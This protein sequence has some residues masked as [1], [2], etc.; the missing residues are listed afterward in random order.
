MIETGMNTKEQNKKR[1][2]ESALVNKFT[3]MDLRTAGLSD[4]D[5]SV[6]LDFLEE[7]EN[8]D[9][10]N[11]YATKLSGG[12][13]DPIYESFWKALN[14]TIAKQG[15]KPQTFMLHPTQYERLQSWLNVR[16]VDVVSDPMCP[17]DKAYILDKTHH[18]FKPLTPLAPTP[19]PRNPGRASL[20]HAATLTN[21][22]S[23]HTLP[24]D[25]EDTE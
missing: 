8:R 7:C 23:Q 3:L 17:E 18:A 22:Y 6:C 14:R 5:I 16:G 20:R 12:R 13:Y 2:E 19:T 21:I 10:F 15:G 25:P 11:S 24:V 1:A 4:C 9:E